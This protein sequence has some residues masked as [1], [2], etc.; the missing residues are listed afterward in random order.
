MRTTESATGFSALRPVRLGSAVRGGEEG[1]DGGG[2]GEEEAVAFGAAPG[3]VG[4]GLGDEEL[5]RGSLER[6]IDAQT[7]PTSLSVGL[8]PDLDLLREHPAL[9]ALVRRLS[10]YAGR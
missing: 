8:I 3:E 7:G 2:R 9:G 6:N 4:D 5:L 1:V 10:L